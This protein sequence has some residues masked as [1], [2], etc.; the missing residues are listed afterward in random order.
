MLLPDEVCQ[1]TADFLALVDAR[2]P[3]LVEALYLHGSLGWDEYFPGQSDVDFLTVMAVR[4][5]AGQVDALA[6]AHEALRQMHPRPYFDGSHVVRADL[7]APPDHCPD[8][9]GTLEG[10]FEPAGRHC[11]NPVTWHELANRGITVRG[12][13]VTDGQVWTDEAALRA[14]SY[15]NLTSYWAR[16]PDSLTRNPDLA[17]TPW[18]A[19]WCVTGVSRLHHL[20]A[21]GTLTSKSGGGRHALTV[22]GERW[23]PIINEALRARERPDEPSTYDSDPAGRGRD[24]IAFT[25]MAIDAALALGC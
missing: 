25:L 20:L 17:A 5:S 7:A 24:T 3:G 16:W 13:D 1:V 2:A 15:A 12:P 10:K 8:V 23:H 9:P 21:T 4:P 19:M 22:F 18:A 11:L 14:F 6:A